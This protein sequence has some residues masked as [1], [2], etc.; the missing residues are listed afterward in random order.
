MLYYKMPSK[1][2][3][4]RLGA[5]VV[6]NDIVVPQHEMDHV[7]ETIKKK[8]GGTYL[9][10]PI[11]C[12]CVAKLATGFYPSESAD[13]NERALISKI[14][15]YHYES[16]G[17]SDGTLDWDNLTERRRG[18]Y[19]RLDLKDACD[20]L[21]K[22]NEE[23]SS[24]LESTSRPIKK[25]NREDVQKMVGYNCDK[26]SEWR[27]KFPFE[28]KG[29][30]A[31]PVVE[32]ELSPDDPVFVLGLSSTLNYYKF[33]TTHMACP[34]ARKYN[35]SPM[36]SWNVM[37]N[38]ASVVCAMYN[39][40]N[41]FPIQ[42]ILPSDMEA[43]SN[44]EQIAREEG[45]YRGFIVLR[46]KPE[47]F[48]DEEKSF[49]HFVRPAD[50]VFEDPAIVL[51]VYRNRFGNPNEVFS[52]W[53]PFSLVNVNSKMV[54]WGDFSPRKRITYYEIRQ[55]MAHLAADGSEFRAYEL[56][57]G[58]DHG[59]RHIFV[60]R[61]S[62]PRSKGLVPAC[63]EW[64]DDKKLVVK[65]SD[66]CADYNIPDMDVPKLMKWYLGDD[67]YS[68]QTAGAMNPNTVFDDE[69]AGIVATFVDKFGEDAVIEALEIPIILQASTDIILKRTG[70]QNIQIDDRSIYRQGKKVSDYVSW[71]QEFAKFFDCD[72]ELMRLAPGV[73]VICV[74]F[75]VAISAACLRKGGKVT[76]FLGDTLNVSHI[77][78]LKELA[79]SF[80]VV[81]LGPFMSDL[82]D[83]APAPVC[84]AMFL[85]VLSA[86][87]APS[88]ALQVMNTLRIAKLKLKK[89]GRLW[90]NIYIP[91]PNSENNEV[92]VN[93]IHILRAHFSSTEVIRYYLSVPGIS[94]IFSGFDNSVPSG[95]MDK[96]YS[97]LCTG[98]GGVP[99]LS[100]P[101]SN[102]KTVLRNIL[103][104]RRKRVVSSLN[105]LKKSNKIQK[106]GNEPH[107][108]PIMYRGL[109]LVKS[110]RDYDSANLSQEYL[111]NAR[112]FEPR[113]H[114]GQLKLFVSELDFLLS[115]LETPDEKALVVYAGAAAGHHIPI[116]VKM[117]PNTIWHLYDKS[118]FHSTVLNIPRVK[119]FRR[120]FDDGIA[121]EYRREKGK[122]LFVSDIRSGTETASIVEDMTSQARWC[123]S[124]NPF[125]TS[126]KI[127]F[128]F[129][130]D[131]FASP[132]PG[133]FGPGFSGKVKKGEFLYLKGEIK[134]QAFAP[135]NS[136]ETRLFVARPHELVPYSVADYERRCYYHNINVRRMV[137]PEMV[138]P[139][140]YMVLGLDRGWESLY[141]FGTVMRYT[142]SPKEAARIVAGVLEKLA[143]INR[144][145]TCVSATYKKYIAGRHPNHSQKSILKLWLEI[146][147]AREKDM[148]TVQRARIRNFRI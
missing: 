6:K 2:R 104:A 124:M 9:P 62:D 34:F 30:N 136:P 45:T 127:R 73:P 109:C 16:L 22:V 147:R 53:T 59:D 43:L 140:D 143:S 37:T 120:L 76:H 100:T 118:P 5:N 141:F 21:G 64:D 54:D 31:I 40:K 119:L 28:T 72:T 96:L 138:I 145:E 148:M 81:P 102:T 33:D 50:N 42:F 78:K 17:I 79:K 107:T 39:S 8:T 46:F 144:L 132:D 89:G 10:P 137:Q 101:A 11:A 97:F 110:F 18:R 47:D 94:I 112:D 80:D 69:T 82:S 63:F 51:F 68:E 139:I 19:H 67:T 1:P 105:A 32:N 24:M 86:W 131:A 58:A 7:I 29:R 35:V 106:G 98:S 3:V 142:E 115:A 123:I 87:Y 146:T 27:N 84:D 125:A 56:T 121:A 92:L 38:M 66:K 44:D 48:Y 26:P 99:E 20:I 25:K 111:E 74:S 126:L 13:E 60:G 117:F 113:C 4:P 83:V 52:G 36:V 91:N 85:D 88:S 134:Y 49:G 57:G 15:E 116:L 114:F 75:S 93:A 108:P 135:M 14:F 41:A 65:Q 122:L 128:P 77:L 103:G 55:V 71:F 129:P 133:S 61:H 23:A 95:D 12:L 90:A 130:T 70:V